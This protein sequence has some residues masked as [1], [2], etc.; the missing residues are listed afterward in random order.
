MVGAPDAPWVTALYDAAIEPELWPVALKSVADEVGADVGLLFGVD[1]HIAG[2]TMLHCTHDGSSLDAFGNRHMD[3]MW[4]RAAAMKPAP[5]VAR[6]EDLIPVEQL[7]QSSFY[8]DVLEPAGLFHSLGA[9]LT[10]TRDEFVC[11]SFLRPRA[12]HAFD[13]D[14]MAWMKSAVPHLQRAALV[15]RRL[16]GA[17]MLCAAALETLSLLKSPLFLL[18]GEGRVLFLNRAAEGLLGG[19]AGLR[20]Q[21]GRL[22][23]SS[24]E[25]TSRI[26]RLLCRATHEGGYVSVPRQDRAGSVIFHLARL[27]DTAIRLRGRVPMFILFAG[28]DGAAVDVPCEILQEAFGFTEREANVALL[29]TGGRGLPAIARTLGVSLNT[30]RSHAARVYDKTG[31]TGQLQLLIELLSRVPQVQTGHPRRTRG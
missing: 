1:F 31:T 16:A 13:G 6:T 18:D 15:T 27:G 17:D 29:L 3:N 24:R 11:V 23:A 25:S 5:S 2:P 8:A 21:D 22:H 10:K 9:N 4:S 12:R 19:S 28:T 20:M 7:V 30:V 26:Q 14:E